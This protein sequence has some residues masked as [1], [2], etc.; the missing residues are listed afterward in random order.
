LI[1]L[2]F[3]AILPGMAL[4]KRQ[5]EFLEFL[6]GFLEKRGYSPSYEEIAEG[7]S[8]ASLATVHKHIL[9]LESKHYVKR[10]FNQSRS[11][12]LAPK[13]Y[14]EQRQFRPPGLEVPLLGRIAAGA[15]VEAIAGNETL[16]FSDF[17][18]D[19]G[20]YALQVRGESMIEDHICDGDYVLVQRTDGARDGD[21]VVA[22]VDGMETTLKRFYLEPGDRVRLQPA[23]AAMA[24]IYVARASVQIQGKVLAVLRR[25]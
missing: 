13:Y 8:L 21:I 16:S 11:L 19:S 1:F 9:A 10:G 23:N 5:K 22:L 25:Y 7:L 14:D 4:T 17:T 24:P 15:P 12:E 20:T 3:F 2:F 18:G 6:A